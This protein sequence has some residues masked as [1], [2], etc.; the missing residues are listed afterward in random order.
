MVDDGASLGVVIQAVIE[1]AGDRYR[2]AF[3]NTCAGGGNVVRSIGSSCPSATP[4]PE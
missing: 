1:L 3:R 2:T 4:C